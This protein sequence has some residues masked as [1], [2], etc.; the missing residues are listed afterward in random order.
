MKNIA[1]DQVHITGGFWK[2]KQEMLLV[3]SRSVYER[4]A[5]TYRFEAVNVKGWLAR[6]MAEEA[7]P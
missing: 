2:A 4:F 7:S 3:T 5:E 1:Y 6:L